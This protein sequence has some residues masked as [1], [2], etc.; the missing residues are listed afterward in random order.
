MSEQPQAAPGAAEMV[1][2]VTGLAKTYGS[3]A[4][5]RGLSFV[6]P[7]GSFYGM[8]GRNGAGKTTTFDAVTGLIGRDAGRVRMFGEE[9]GMEPSPEA[10]ARIAYVGGHILLYDWLTLQDHLRFVAGFYATWDEQRCQ[11]LLR[12]FR[13]PMRQR[14]G[15]LSPGQHLQFQLLMALSRRPELLIL[16]EPG[17]LDVVVRQQLMESVLPLLEAP[18][19][20]TGAAGT[21][22]MATHLINELEGVCDNICIIEGG[23][24]LAAGRVDDLIREVRTVHFQGVTTMEAP[25]LAG[26]WRHRLGPEE[27]E[28]VLPVFDEAL[29]ERLRGELGARSFEVGRVS[30]EEYFIALTS[31][32]EARGA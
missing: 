20:A 23:V 4:A 32:Q 8:L 21:V 18:E 6:V 2:E 28:V 27:L 15:T 14:V 24:A 3:V 19:R 17:N 1:L 16:D 11:E 10:K 30:L 7:R 29:A 22:I 13:L 25:A 12:V 26:L 5:L 9:V 31:A